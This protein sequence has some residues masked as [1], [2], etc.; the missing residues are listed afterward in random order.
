MF[1]GLGRHGLL[2]LLKI[3]L[4]QLQDVRH[5]I[6]DVFRFDDQKAFSCELVEGLVRADGHTKVEALVD[7][8]WGHVDGGGELVVVSKFGHE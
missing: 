3:A 7:E 8:E 4:H 5:N 2:E 6:G 1:V